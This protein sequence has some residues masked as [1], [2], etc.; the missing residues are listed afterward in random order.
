[1]YTIAAHQDLPPLIQALCRPEAWPHPVDT[2]RVIETHSAWVLLTGRYAYKIKRPVQLG[3]TDF[4]TLAK[5]RS[6]CEQELQLN[7]RHASALYDSIV[8]ICGE[9]SEPVVLDIDN[10]DGTAIE[11][12]VKM[13]EFQQSQQLDRQLL[14]GQIDFGDM[15]ELAAMVAEL[16]ISA[17][18]SPPDSL[19]G[20]VEHITQPA[21][22]IFDDLEPLIDDSADL[23]TIDKLREWTSTRAEQLAPVM[24]RRKQDHFVRECHGDMHLSN[25]A[26]F[27]GKFVPFDCIEFDADLRWRDVMSEVAFLTM[28]LAARKRI[29]LAW[30]FL[31][32]YL[33][34]SGD[35]GG[36]TMLRFYIVFATMARARVAAIRAEQTPPGTELYAEI[37]RAYRMHLALAETA[38]RPR[39]PVI[40][41]T[42]GASGSGKAW[43]TSRLL[44]AL[45][46]IRIRSDIERRRLHGI[47]E[48]QKNEAD[49]AKGIYSE[50]LSRE[51]YEYL[52]DRT[53][54]IITAR[55]DVIIDATF[56]RR[57]QRELFYE[58]GNQNNCPVVILDCH[59]EDRVLRDRI[60]Q[61]K[62]D[63]ADGSEIDEA[64]L[65][66][67]QKSLEP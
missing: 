40:I 43:L 29:D 56:L 57:E 37:A 61:R 11:Y 31:N 18:A 46:A 19:Y 12:A 8:K 50:Q 63:G 14:A 7:R 34:L 6:A 45:P 44:S 59:A 36:A 54:D 55:L 4:S 3:F 52:R 13:R 42:M 9:E 53:Q 30:R 22:R 67:Q 64:V 35:Y 1:M 38:V 47:G 26:A 17:P 28:D 25:I 20:S 66:F 16:H 41:L 24:T 10:E 32:R 51:I 58:L 60:R 15:D 33:E 48:T 49:I 23:L 5:R 39:T 62:W 2:V 27:E 65:K 21:L